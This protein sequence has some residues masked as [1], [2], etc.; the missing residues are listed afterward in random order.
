MEELQDVY[1][2]FQLYHGANLSKML[3]YEQAA[4]AVAAADGDGAAAADQ[5]AAMRSAVAK[6]KQP[7]MTGRYAICV[8]N[9]LGTATFMLFTW[10]SCRNVKY[11]RWI[12]C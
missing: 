8:Q 11:F 6:F 9:G 7:T 12:C 3:L 1:D 5:N 4:A 2:E 10:Q